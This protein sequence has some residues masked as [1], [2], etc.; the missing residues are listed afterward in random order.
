M[1]QL[2]KDNNLETNG[3]FCD[4]HLRVLF[5]CAIFLLKIKWENWHNFLYTIKDT[6]HYMFKGK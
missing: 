5:S 2:K 3:K 6:L 1:F 4:G